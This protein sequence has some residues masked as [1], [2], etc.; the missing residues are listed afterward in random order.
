MRWIPLRLTYIGG[1][2][3]LIE[4]GGVRLLTDPTFDPAP[5][6]YPTPVYTLH[7]T[8]SP[9]IGPDAIGRVDA[10][11]LSHD[12]HFDNL[13]NAGRQILSR[14]G[15]VL[16]TTDGAKRLGGNAQGLNAWQSTDVAVEGG[17]QLRITAT[18]ARHGPARG[19]RGP[20]IGF[21]LSPSDDPAD[22][23]YVSGDTVWYEGVAEVA[24]RFPVGVAVLF[25]GAAKVAVAGPAHIT[26]SAAD[27]IEAA[28]AFPHATIVPVH[29]EGW[30]HFSEAKA[31]IDQAF[32]D[33][34]LHDRLLWLRAGVTTDIR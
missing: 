8:Q 26:F 18:P 28:R 11:L 5:R 20:C 30:T 32:R 7:K 21:V 33:A 2:T 3:L 17:A 24:R 6:D 34:G 19:D 27:G 10:V 16:T 12:H 31:D 4:I 23:V 9:A 25:M 29:F 22:A 15:R 13:D 1:P 14:A